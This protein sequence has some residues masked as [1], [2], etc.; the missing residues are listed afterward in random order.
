MRVVHDRTAP[1]PRGNVCGE[2]GREV[3]RDE[4]VAVLLH[5]EDEGAEDVFHE[6]QEFRDAALP[7]GDATETQ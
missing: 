7:R 5:G 1:E 6:A 3:M 4:D 2:H